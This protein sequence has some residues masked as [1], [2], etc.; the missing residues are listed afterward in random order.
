MA[1][2]EAEPQSGTEIL[3]QSSHPTFVFVWPKPHLYLSSSHFCICLTKPHLYFYLHNT[4]VC[5][6]L[7]FICVRRA[8]LYFSW[9]GA[10]Q[11]RSECI[12]SLYSIYTNRSLLLVGGPLGTQ[13]VWPMQVTKKP[14]KIWSFRHQQISGRSFCCH[15]SR[16][17]RSSPLQ[18]H[19]NLC[20]D[21]VVWVGGWKY[22]DSV[23]Q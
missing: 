12:L 21:P 14:L 13:V 6:S 20:C 23:V 8:Y 9:M 16:Y 18:L 4:F 3:L 5:P 7:I 19:L 15:K 17:E 10:K 1:W 11:E 22:I 2:E